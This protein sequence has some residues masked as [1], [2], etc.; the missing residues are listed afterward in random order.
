MEKSSQ[1]ECK[2]FEL[3]KQQQGIMEDYIYFQMQKN[4]TF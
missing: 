3:K 4:A 2:I 1:M